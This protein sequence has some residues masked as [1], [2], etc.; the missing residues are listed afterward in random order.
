MPYYEYTCESC[1]KVFDLRRPFSESDEK[2]GCPTCGASCARAISKTSF[3]LKGAGWAKDGYGNR[4]GG[5]MTSGRRPKPAG[6]MSTI[7][8]TDQ[9]GNLR[10]AKTHEKL[11]EGKVYGL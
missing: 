5:A 2:G 4:G 1:D 11:D 9:G 6:D 8:Y 3:V 10:D 7:P